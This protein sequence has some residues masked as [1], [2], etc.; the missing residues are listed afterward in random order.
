MW[1]SLLDTFGPLII[2]VLSAG[3]TEGA[4]RITKRVPRAALPWLSAVVGAACTALP[5]LEAMP[6]Q[7]GG[8][9]GLAGAGL[10]SGLGKHL[11]KSAPAAK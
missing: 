9:L 4:K 5:G 11:V 2:P 6:A 3:V 7:M 10:W 1:K 8:A